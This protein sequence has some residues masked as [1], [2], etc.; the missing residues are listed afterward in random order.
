MKKIETTA[1]DVIRD[2]YIT[3]KGVKIP[4][5]DTRTYPAKY[6][7]L[8]EAE[9]RVQHLSGLGLSKKQ[10]ALVLGVEYKTFTNYLKTHPSLEREYAAG[11]IRAVSKVASKMY[12]HALDGSFPAM[13]F[14]LK[15]RAP[16]LWSDKQ[17][18]VHSGPPIS[19]VMDFGGEISEQAKDKPKDNGLDDTDL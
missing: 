2:N 4:T 19:F 8:P 10:I 17:E 9:D 1:D 13:S 7:S 3:S 16:G 15:N 18:V 14:F 12:E 5:D 6:L 11:S